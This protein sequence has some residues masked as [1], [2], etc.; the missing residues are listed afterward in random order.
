MANNKSAPQKLIWQTD[1]ADGK[2]LMAL[3][4][5]DR[6]AN[7]ELTTLLALSKTIKDNADNTPKEI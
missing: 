2:N 1:K 4:Q 7:D 6:K 3:L 5:N